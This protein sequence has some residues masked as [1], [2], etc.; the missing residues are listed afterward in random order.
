[1][2]MVVHPKG[3]PDPALYAIDQFILRGGRAML[4]VDPWAEVDTGGAD[5]GDPMGGMAGGRS[6]NLNKLFAAWGISVTGDKFVGDDRYALQVMGPDGRPVRDIGLVGIDPDG[7]DKEDVVTAGLNVLNFGFAGAIS[8]ADKAPVKLTPL[9]QSSDLAALVN[10]APL[11]FMSDPSLLRENFKPSGQRYTIAGRVSGKVPSAFPNGP[12]DGVPPGGKPHLAA[13]ENP[14]NV[15]IVADSD[16]LSD[17][18]W[19][20]TQNFFGQPMA[21]AFANN[22]DFVVNSLDNLLGSSDLIG[23]RGRATFSRPF[24][25]VQEL[26]RVAEDKFRVT[27]D[28]LKQEL[29]ETEKKLGDLQARREDRNA[30]ILSPEQEK[31]LERFRTQRVD[32]RKELRQVQHSLD[33]DIERLGNWLKVINIG[34]MPVLV[35]VAG[36]VLLLIRRRRQSGT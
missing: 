36:I 22:G 28:R 33:Q 10:T 15:V 35:A 14:I 20:Q 32:I 3:L 29:Q 5:P 16:F 26:R 25:R 9:V 27:E 18:L 21:H 1:V 8:A 11:G 23:I 34:L 12:P 4:F 30:M 19:V 7:F 6:S 13:S 17:R 24:T 2:L 31:E